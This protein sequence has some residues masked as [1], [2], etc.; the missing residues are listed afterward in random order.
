MGIYN[1]QPRFVP[2]IE[3]GAKTHT[4][5]ANRLHADVPGNT[6]H[7]YTGLRQRGA[8]L[9]MRTRCTD[10]QSIVITGR[11]HVYVD[12]VKLSADECEVLARLDGFDNFADMMA[13]WPELFA[14]EKFGRAGRCPWA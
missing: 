6:L 13:F 11:E 9:I 3:S 8:R 10:V 1:F 5:R 4:I 14:M 12:E 2:L 7:L